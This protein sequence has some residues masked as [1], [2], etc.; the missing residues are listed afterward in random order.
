MKVVRAAGDRGLRCLV[1]SA[2]AAVAATHVAAQDVEPETSAVFHAGPVAFTPSLYIPWIGVDSNVFNEPRNPKSDVTGQIQPQIQVWT[3][4]RRARI[5]ANE[6]LSFVYFRSYASERA[7]NTNG[8]VR[9]SLQLSRAT[10]YVGAAFVKTNDRPS[11]E[12]DTR[13]Q[14][15]RNPITAGVDFSVSAKVNLDLGTDYEHVNFQSGQ[16]FGLANLKNE[17]DR[18]TRAYRATLRYSMTP[19]KAVTLTVLEQDSTFQF[20][21]DRNSHSLR[22]VPGVVFAPFALITGRAEVGML[23]YTPL[24]TR[25]RGFSGPVANVDLGYVLL[26]ATRFSVQASRDV[27]P[28]VDRVADYFIQMGIAATV[29]HRISERWDALAGTNRLRLDYGNNAT[30]VAAATATGADIVRSYNAG[31]GFYFSRG[32]RVGVRGEHVSRE[33]GNPNFNYQNVRLMTTLN[34]T[35][36]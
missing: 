9:F 13:A 33:S 18:T 3:R 32:L 22:V 25:I 15:R 27:V 35:F 26:G 34:F 23:R 36:R 29:T 19:L 31:L 2:M 14:Q 5:S 6:V 12:I 28:S 21:P 24:D 1:A 4:F 20:S 11:P 17:L 30:T 7:V 10:P 8:N 16:T